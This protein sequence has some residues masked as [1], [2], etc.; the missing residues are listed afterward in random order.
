[1]KKSLTFALVSVGIVVGI[2]GMTNSFIFLTFPAFATSTS[3][4]SIQESQNQ[5]QSK[6]TVKYKPL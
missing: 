4:D 5:L 6:L 3:S 2:V 1:M